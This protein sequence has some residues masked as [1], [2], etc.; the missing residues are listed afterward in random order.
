MWFKNLRIF[1]LTQA[2]EQQGEHLEEALETKLFQPCGKLDPLKH[3]WVSPLGRSGKVLAF[4]NGGATMLCAKRQEKSVPGNVLNDALETKI[5]EI[6]EE[7]GRPVG[8]KERQDMKDELIF[9]LLPNTLPRTSFEFAY[10]NH[11]DKLIYVNLSASKKAEDL[12]TLL[13]E[14]LGTLKAVPL[15][16]H[17]PIA[18]VLTDWLRNG[19]APA[20]FSLGD[21]CELRATKD[22]RVVRFRKHD[23][24][25]DE[26]RQHL[27][28]GMHVR[29]LSLTWKET[30]S[31]TIDDELAIKSMSFSD[32]LLDKVSELNAEDDATAFDNEFAFMH[33]ELSAFTKDLLKAFGGESELN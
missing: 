10:V 30:L 12:L 4:G 1:R 18:P 9:S 26:V 33:A 19:E 27:D 11:H 28:T 23:L 2:I 5:F 21:V 32:E 25:A 15:G 8:R 22:E 31:F 17:N 7:E 3:G 14:S 13:R 24:S 29:S 6:R 16:T 20:P